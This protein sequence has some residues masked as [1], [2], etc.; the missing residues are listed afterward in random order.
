VSD[1]DWIRAALERYE[2]PLVVY[3]ARIA[4]GLD[5]AR[6]A[7]QDTFLELCAADRAAV[8]PRLA[9]WLFTVCRNKAIDLAR[10]SRTMKHNT[11]PGA[12]APHEP[13]SAELDPSA[14]ALRGDDH[15]QVQAHVARLPEKQQEVLRLRFQ[16]GLAYKEIA[17]VTGDSIGN[18]GTLLHVALRS[19][20]ERLSIEGKVTS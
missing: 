1:S 8:E 11:T 10:R 13:A 9:A 2:T 12:S 3:A 7:V 20:R 15:A 4:G 16:A 19:L 17:A 14:A 6:D 5:A 18:V